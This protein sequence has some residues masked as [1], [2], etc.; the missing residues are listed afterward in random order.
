MKLRQGLHKRL[1]RT[2]RTEL[3]W[4]GGR[5][6]KVRI[7][8]REGGSERSGFGAERA[9]RKGQDLERRGRFREGWFGVGSGE[10]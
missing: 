10:N 2:E 4:V 9:V 1:D 5:F 8:S 6:G 7:W 3:A